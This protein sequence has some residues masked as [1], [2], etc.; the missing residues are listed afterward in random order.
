[1]PCYKLKETRLD[2][3]QQRE[4]CLRALCLRE[5]GGCEEEHARQL[6]MIARLRRVCMRAKLSHVPIAL[7]ASQ[8]G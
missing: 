4:L 2:C 3:L 6:T 1:M 7:A 8:W 5:V